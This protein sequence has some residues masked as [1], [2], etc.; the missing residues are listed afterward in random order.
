[1][2]SK[3]DPPLLYPKLHHKTSVNVSYVLACKFN[4]MRYDTRTKYASVAERSIATDCKSVVFGLRRFESYPAHKG[5]KKRLYA[6]FLF[7]FA[8]PDRIRRTEPG[9]PPPR[10]QI[11]PAEGRDKSSWARGRRVLVL[12]APR[13]FGAKRTKIRR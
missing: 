11:Y 2:A 13:S 5:T 7:T 6:S 10:L 3:T 1:M 4:E 9:L 8:T 12:P